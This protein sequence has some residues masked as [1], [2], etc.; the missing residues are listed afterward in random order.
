LEELLAALRSDVALL[1]IAT[2]EGELRGQTATGPIVVGPP[3]EQRVAVFCGQ[4]LAM[5]EALRQRRRFALTVLET[6]RV[7]S[8][9]ARFAAFAP[10]TDDVDL[11]EQLTLYCDLAEVHHLESGVLLLGR[12]TASPDPRAAVRIPTPNG[13]FRML[14]VE[15]GEKSVAAAV[16]LIGRPEGSTGTPLYI[17]RG[18][19]LGDA[20]GNLNCPRRRA[21]DE[22]LREMH[23]GGGGVV[24]YY[25]NDAKEFACCAGPKAHPPEPL[26]EATAAHFRDILETLAL[27]APRILGSRRSEEEIAA[28]GFFDVSTSGAG[29]LT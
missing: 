1:T 16:M 26:D 3:Q 20:L 28:L 29:E 15:T 13:A 5:L 10:L 23:D 27:R 21:L 12:V 25:R 18:C 17:H 19:M 24:V 4:D 14:P 7:E 8:V 6:E 9:S 22:V 11:G 2:K